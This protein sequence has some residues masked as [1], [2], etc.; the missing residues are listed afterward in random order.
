MKFNIERETSKQGHG[1]AGPLQAG[2]HSPSVLTGA[3]AEKARAERHVT[4]KATAGLAFS[5]TPRT[6][7][8]RAPQD[9]RFPNSLSGAW[10]RPW[11]MHK[12]LALAATLREEVSYPVGTSLPM[13]CGSD[14]L[15]SLQHSGV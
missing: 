11:L 13:A 5:V 9:A 4:V 10:G 7:S 1:W 8:P 6:H 2:Q 15:G 3:V 14:T 12:Q